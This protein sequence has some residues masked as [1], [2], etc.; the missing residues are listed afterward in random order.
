ML[1]PVR[2]V[3]QSAEAGG[4]DDVAGGVVGLPAGDGLVGG[5]GG[6]DGVDGGVAGVADGGEDELL[7]VGGLAV[8]DAG[9]GD[10]VLDGV[11]A[12]GELGPDVDEDEVAGADGAGVFGGW[13]RSGSRRSWGRR[14]RWGRAPR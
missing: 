13:V 4:A 12:V 11:G 5:E 8:D 7:A 3:N 1:W 2:W 9:P 14:R 10:V 6:L